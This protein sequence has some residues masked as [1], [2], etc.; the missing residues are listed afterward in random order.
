MARVER[1]PGPVRARWLRWRQAFGRTRPGR[2]IKRLLG[3]EIPIPVLTEPDRAVLL[4]IF[5]K[6]ELEAIEDERAH[7]RASPRRL[8]PPAERTIASEPIANVLFVSHCNFRGNSAFHVHAM[9]SELHCRGLSPVIAVPDEPETVEDIGRPPFAVLTLDEV[10]AGALS[11]PDGRGPDLVHAFTPRELVRQLTVDV[12][13]EHGCRYVVH[14]EDNEETVLAAEHGGVSVEGLKE[15][16]V[17]T[18]DRIV[19]PRQANPLRARRFAEQSAGM[20]VLVERLLEFVPEGV[21]S[22]I[23]PAG[24]DE[25]ILAPLESREVARAELG[26]EPEDLAIVYPGNIHMVNIEEMRELWAA[27]AQLRRAGRP[28]VLVKTGWG[29]TQ[30]VTFPSLGNGLRDLGWVPHERVPELLAAADVLVQPGG[31]G[32]FNDYRFPSKLPEFLASGRPVVLPRTNLGLLLR[33]GEEAVV[34]ERGDAEE[35]ATAVARLASDAALRER[36]GLAGKAFA[37]RELRWSTGVDRVQDLYAEIVESGYSAPRPSVLNDVDPPVKII[38]LVPQA[39][40]ATETASAREHGI[41][42]F[43]VEGDGGLERK[44]LPAS[45]GASYVALL[46]NLVMRALLLRDVEDPVVFV[47]SS[48]VWP[49]ED[50]RFAWLSAT[51]AGLRDGARLY[52]AS[53]GLKLAEIELDAIVT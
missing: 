10:R 7:P 18:L 17:T 38:A 5:T 42:G 23:V 2:T 41:Y 37:L 24:F 28:V 21:P 53:R 49:D 35:I 27:V 47:D 4:E 3:R 44:P 12:V 45:A 30:A 20:T 19:R 34:L 14:L 52:Y 8:R 9:A 51:R 36:I 16:P 43:C 22:R 13:A 46:R 39:P 26:L 6:D 33:D 1:P 50:E 31:P 25:R 29:S 32:P 40:S 15:L 48:P 11:F